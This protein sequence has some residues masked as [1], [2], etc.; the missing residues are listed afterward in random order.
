MDHSEHDRPAD[1]DE[2]AARHRRALGERGYA[3]VR[4][5]HT[6]G[7]LLRNA[8]WKTY[9]RATHS[10]FGEVF[11]KINY[12][13]RGTGNRAMGEKEAWLPG[14]F[15]SHFAGRPVAFPRVVDFWQTDGASAVAYE[16]VEHPIRSLVSLVSDD[17]LRP[18]LLEFLRT[19]IT[20]EAPQWWLD[21]HVINDFGRDGDL[22]A[23]P[24]HT[25]PFGFDLD[26]NIA[27]DGQGRLFFYDFE[28]IQ[29]TTRGLQQIY[30]ALRL[31]QSKR[32]ALASLM[33]RGAAVE[34][35]AQVPPPERGNVARQALRA[36]REALRRNGRSYGPSLRW[37]ETIVRWRCR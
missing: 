27:I 5:M 15:A 17:A 16:F 1:P 7:N 9:W 2:A 32:H 29:W 22:P 8:R 11:V 28:F 33:G 37:A 19:W 12:G 3:D 26:D 30:L 13:Y 24:S 4:Q 20:I 34:L 18:V 6:E 31:L 36:Y 14:Y 21:D 23:R 25:A 10:Q 35:I